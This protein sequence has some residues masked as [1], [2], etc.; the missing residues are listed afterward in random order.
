MSA[1]LAGKRGNNMIFNKFGIAS[2]MAGLAVAAT[3]AAAP[4]AV[5]ATTDSTSANVGAP[6]PANT[7]TPGDT[8][9]G[10]KVP[11]GGGQGAVA[12][13]PD[14]PVAVLPGDSVIGGA[15]PYL[16]SGTDPL[17][18]FGVWAQGPMVNTG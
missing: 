16:P 18:P 2:A 17:V 3:L 9:A 8:R 10:Q 11:G 4:S 15:D 1:A 12:L 5:A 6:T 13:P 7:V 14:G